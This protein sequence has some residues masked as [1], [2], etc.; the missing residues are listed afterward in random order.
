MKVR[1]T[2]RQKALELLET[3]RQGPALLKDV[4][5]SEEAPFATDPI[6]NYALW[7]DTWVIP[8]LNELI[9][10]LKALKK[11]QAEVKPA[12]EPAVEPKPMN[13]RDLVLD[14][15]KDG[16]I[17]L[18]IKALRARRYASRRYAWGGDSSLVACK[19]AVETIL[20]EAGR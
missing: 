6:R 13:E 5:P 18:A 4:V 12:A 11:A 8:A 9:P 14:A 7:V 17:L 20:K 10:E 1:G 2:R 19:H 16:G 3:V 15:H